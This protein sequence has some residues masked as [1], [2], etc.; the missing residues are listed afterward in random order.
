M[1]RGY[2]KDGEKMIPP[3]RKGKKASQETK[4]M[5]SL[6]RT[7]KKHSKETL[8][9]MSESNS[10]W[11]SSHTMPKRTAEQ[12]ARISTELK[13]ERSKNNFIELCVSCHKR[14]DSGENGIYSFIKSNG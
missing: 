13:Y 12:C 9:K 5:M 8:R 2:F 3:S 11:W 4:N 14:Y 6:K 1:P 10:H 7:G